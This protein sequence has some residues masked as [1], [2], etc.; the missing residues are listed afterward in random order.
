[1]NFQ[2]IRSA[3]DNLLSAKLLDLSLLETFVELP[4]LSK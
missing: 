2:L 4:V 1:M 3:G